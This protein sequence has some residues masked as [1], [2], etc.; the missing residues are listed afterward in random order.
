M[1]QELSNVIIER[2]VSAEM[3]VL[4]KL[5]AARAVACTV[6]RKQTLHPNHHHLLLHILHRL[7][8]E[9]HETLVSHGSSSN[10]GSPA[11][12]DFDATS[13]DQ[14]DSAEIFLAE[15]GNMSQEEGAMVVGLVCLSIVIDARANSNSLAFYAAVID[16][17]RK[18]EET[19]PDSALMLEEM[20]LEFSRGKPLN[21]DALIAAVGR[22]EVRE[23]VEAPQR[24]CA[25]N[26]AYW[27][28]Q[29]LR[30]FVSCFTRLV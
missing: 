5:Q 11:E 22:R 27:P 12:S 30:R 18:G 15:L 1:K 21:A 10:P 25:Q 9:G 24:T 16:G 17:L 8:L 14:L 19:Y 6:V 7:E 3:T 26:L 23:A 29:A 13:L 20:A 4:G 28:W 2:F